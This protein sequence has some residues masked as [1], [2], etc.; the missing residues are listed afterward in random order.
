MKPLVFISAPY[1]AHPAHCTRV[2]I[3]AGMDLWA[4]GLVTPLVPHLTL[5]ADLVRPMPVEDWYRYDLELL[6]RCDAVYRLP[7][8]STGADTETAAARQL[9]IPV[10]EH[11]EH[12]LRWAEVRRERRERHDRDHRATSD[13]MCEHCRAGSERTAA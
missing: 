13:P 3:E 9:N 10:F 2:A 12:L 11:R 5:L 1:S 4:T 8:D 6:A 7:G